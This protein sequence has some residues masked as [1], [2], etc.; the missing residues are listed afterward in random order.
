MITPKTTSI[1][2]IIQ[3]CPRPF[4]S[5]K[6]ASIM[7]IIEMEKLRI[8]NQRVESETRKRESETS[9]GFRVGL[10]VCSPNSPLLVSDSTLLVS[11]SVPLIRPSP[12]P[13]LSQAVCQHHEM[14]IIQDQKGEHHE[15]H[16]GPCASIRRASIISIIQVCLSQAVCQHQK[17]EH[18]EHHPDLSQAVCPRLST[19]IKGEHHP[20]L[21]M[22]QIKVCP[23]PR[24]SICPQ[25]S[26]GACPKPLASVCIEESEH[27]EHHPGLSQAVCQHHKREHHEHHPGVPGRVPASKSSRSV[28]GR[29]PASKRRPS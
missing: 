28:S 9:L 2:S 27:H 19:S 15:H 13:D 10:R 17:G 14:S 5:I 23:R 8:R 4:A 29:V 12:H 18:H 11:D 1:M 24:I 21:S 7:S 6:R 26:Q 3:V 20:G 16:L 22:C 25:R